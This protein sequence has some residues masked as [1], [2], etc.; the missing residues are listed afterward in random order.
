MDLYLQSVTTAETLEREK[1][2]VELKE[3]KRDAWKYTFLHTPKPLCNLTVLFR[4]DEETGIL[5]YFS[6]GLL[7]INGEV[8]DQL[9]ESESAEDPR[10][11]EFSSFRPS[12]PLPAFLQ[13]TIDIVLHFHTPH[14]LDPSLIRVIADE[15]QCT[16]PEACRTE[17]W[18]LPLEH[19]TLCVEDG[20]LTSKETQ[21]RGIIHN[22]IS[23]QVAMN[24]P[25]VKQK[26]EDEVLLERFDLSSRELEEKIEDLVAWSVQRQL[27][28][29]SIIQCL[30]MQ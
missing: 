30:D 27:L 5:S 26:F 17:K 8:V 14:D 6:H 12:C 19:A 21:W 16:I 29:N 28:R 1:D 7:R 11:T 22:D 3:K 10:V 20:K 24:T 25:Y 4:G 18:V 23:Q 2:L 9:Q 15:V 13:C